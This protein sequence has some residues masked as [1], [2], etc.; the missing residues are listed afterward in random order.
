MNRPKAPA[1]TRRSNKHNHHHHNHS[2][3][4]SGN[5]SIG[6]LAA[7]ESS[8]RRAR[9]RRSKEDRLDTVG[10]PAA[11]PA[12]AGPASLDDTAAMEVELN[13]AEDEVPHNK[14]NIRETA[15]MNR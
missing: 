7:A 5:K 1:A 8:A 9:K 3:D 14:E 10:R 11:Q 13:G 2:N 6:Q 12:S 4:S 15:R